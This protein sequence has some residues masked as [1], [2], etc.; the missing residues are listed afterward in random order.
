MVSE[1]ERTT[2]AALSKDERTVDNLKQE[3]A[4][5]RSEMD[6]IPELDRGAI[7]RLRAVKAEIKERRREV[8]ATRQT[9]ERLARS[10]NATM[11][12]MA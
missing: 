10:I 8:E 2:L 3:L 9:Q 6:L 5:A 11:V 12:R 7:E 4:E 1:E